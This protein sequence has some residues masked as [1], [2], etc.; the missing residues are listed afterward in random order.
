MKK[1]LPTLL[2]ILLLSIALVGTTYAFLY[3]VS[4][5]CKIIGAVGL[6]VIFVSV[7]CLA[8]YDGRCS[9]VKRKR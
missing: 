7:A 2:I 9:R 6:L 3:E 8:G 5:N 4:I 1:I